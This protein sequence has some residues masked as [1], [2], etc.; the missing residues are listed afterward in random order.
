MP[1]HVF[2]YPSKVRPYIWQHIHIQDRGPVPRLLA[3]SKRPAGF[4]QFIY[5]EL[6]HA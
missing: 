1:D 6:R 3:V 4:V 5:Y 2:S